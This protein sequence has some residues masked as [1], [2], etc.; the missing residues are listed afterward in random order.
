MAEDGRSQ[1][2]AQV[3]PYGGKHRPQLADAAAFIFGFAL[4]AIL[5]LERI[6]KEK[7]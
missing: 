7:R 1:P 4:A 5:V 6:N 2:E 3:C